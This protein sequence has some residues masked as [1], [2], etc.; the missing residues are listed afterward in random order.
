MMNKVVLTG[1]IE[2]EVTTVLNNPEFMQR[3]F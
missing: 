1:K 3:F 2:G